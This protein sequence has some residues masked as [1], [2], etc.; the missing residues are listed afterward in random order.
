MSTDAS[1]ARRVA[2]AHLFDDAALF[3]PASATVTQALSD[4]AAHHRSASSWLV[5]RFLT[6]AASLEKVR[7]AW[8]AATPLPVVVVL[9]GTRPP[10]PYADAV[11]DDLRH[12][13]GLADAGVQLTGLE[14]PLPDDQPAPLG[15][16]TL[17]EV[18][19]QSALP[20]PVTV[21]CEV[22]VAGRPAA[23]T[24][25]AVAALAAARLAGPP[26]VRSLA[27]KVRCGGPD[28]HLYPDDD[29]LA[30]FVAAC[31]DE[32]LSFKATA[33]LHHPHRRTDPD[34]GM[35]QHG[36]LNLL[37]AAGLACATGADA[38]TL[39][40]AL[41]HR[42]PAAVRLTSDA[43][44]TPEAD[45]DAAALRRARED[46]LGHIGCCAISEPVADLAAAGVLGPDGALA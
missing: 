10:T 46:L 13:V 3:P 43:L 27:A 18:I 31:R 8:G 25:A 39:A 11:A 23:E 30:A 41:G 28:P 6:P 24:H 20:E 5:G 1:D 22:P 12:I 15:L 26:G 33:G 44:H 9:R 42:D 45:L 35:L 17:L 32:G 40:A 14:A 38:G 36:F 4:H 29:H 19:A 37:A 16:E 34:T 21:A 7:H 2:L